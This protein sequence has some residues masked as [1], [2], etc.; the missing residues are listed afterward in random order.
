L[1]TAVL[2]I[3]NFFLKRCLDVLTL[4]GFGFLATNCSGVAVQRQKYAI[5]LAKAKRFEHGL[6]MKYR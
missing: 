1:E 3:R 4:D 6:R 5:V 2:K